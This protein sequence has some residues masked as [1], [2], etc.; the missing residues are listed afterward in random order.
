MLESLSSQA[1]CFYSCMVST[2]M[3]IVT[4]IIII[5]II[6]LLVLFSVFR[7]RW[8][9]FGSQAAASF[10][11]VANLAAMNCPMF[12]WFWFYLGLITIGIIFLTMVHSILARRVEREVIVTP[13]MVEA[14]AKKLDIEVRILD[15][16][17]V[18]AFSFR[19][20]VYV[21][22]G[23]LERLNRDEIEA[24]L[25]HEAY[26]VRYSP[27]KVYTS[28]LALSSLSF[29]KYNDESESDGFAMLTSGK[30]SL[31][32]ALEKLEIRNRESRILM[33]ESL[34]SRGWSPTPIRG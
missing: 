5:T 1:G 17:K 11:I 29:L 14:I 24:V 2:N 33:A 3:H 7:H 4:G 30:D 22:I 10:A 25:A 34:L 19:R 26:H 15:T 6:A 21:S 32:N 31:A 20:K 13:K 18:K 27:N 23:V 9:V 8:A 16:Q 12:T 28:L